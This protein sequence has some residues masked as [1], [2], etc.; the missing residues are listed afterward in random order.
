MAG[1]L[2]ERGAVVISADAQGHAVLEAGGE[3]HAAVVERW[4]EVV[5]DGFISRGMLAAI[6]F[7][8]PDALKELESLTHPA[9][10]GRIQR[11]VDAAG[12]RPVVI[13]LPVLEGP[14]AE[15]GDTWQH[16]LVE[17]P[18]NLRRARSIERGLDPGDVEARMSA[19]PTKAARLEWA[20][21][22]IVNDGTLGDLEAEVDAFWRRL[23]AQ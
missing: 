22:V 23:R 14:V 12:D 15:P 3:A 19:Q 17:A 9:I 4:P 1:L 11:L 13:E 10:A 8:D 6:V 20:D 5:D 2:A 18:Q 7:A 16:V 21:V